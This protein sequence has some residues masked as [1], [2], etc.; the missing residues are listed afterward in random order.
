MTTKD[1]ILQELEQMPEVILRAVLDFVQFL[2]R[3]YVKKTVADKFQQFAG[4]LSDD[5][6]A[7]IQAMVTTEFE[8]VDLNEW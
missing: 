7:S 5:E 4:I 2:K 3:G 1:L 8:Q 6:A